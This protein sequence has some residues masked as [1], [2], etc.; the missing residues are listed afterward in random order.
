MC[1]YVNMHPSVRPCVFMC[2]YVYVHVCT[3]VCVYMSVYVCVC[4]CMRSCV[5]VSLC[6]CVSVRVPLC[7]PVPV[8]GSL[9]RGRQR[10]AVRHLPASAASTGR[11]GNVYHTW[12][13]RERGQGCVTDDCV[14][15]GPRLLSVS[16]RPPL[17]ASP[18]HLRLTYSPACCAW[19]PVES[20]LGPEQ[21]DRR[22]QGEAT[23]T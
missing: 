10:P 3:C 9:G 14:E 20:S 6:R 16:R 11:R 5:H 21:G 22:G 19:A 23:L 2:V 18:A 7:L 1:L 8:W 15:G 4:L 12:T 13:P 17:E